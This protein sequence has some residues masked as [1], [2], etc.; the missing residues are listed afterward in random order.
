MNDPHVEALLYQVTHGESVDYTK[1]AILEHRAPDFVVRLEQLRARVELIAHF[2]TIAE[3]REAVEPFL[4]A[5]ELAAALAHKN[6]DELRFVY[7]RADVIDRNPTPGHIVLTESARITISTGTA[8][9][10]VGRAHYPQPPRGLSRDATVD[11][12]FDRYRMYREGKTTLADA[13]NYVLTALEASSM[14]FVAQ[15]PSRARAAK[16]YDIDETVLRTVGRLAG[17]KGGREARKY[18]SAT[19]D[20]T[21]SERQWLSDVIPLIVRRG[22]ERAFDPHV[23]LPKVTMADLPALRLEGRTD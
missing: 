23:P 17:T 4:Q 14:P 1:A 3:A 9:L 13:A 22:A 21:D 16:Y 19:T 18:E 5:W 10:I 6:P 8:T 2:A 7:D 20:F 12:M 15:G 11:L